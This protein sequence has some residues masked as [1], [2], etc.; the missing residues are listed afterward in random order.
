MKVVLFCGGY[1]TRLREYSETIPKPLVE[2]GYRPIIWHLMKYYAHFGHKDFILAL[3]YRGDLIKDYFLQY[4]ECM[5]NDFVLT[6]G[7]RN[8]ELLSS[9]IDDW[10]ITFCDTGPN[11]NIGQRL[12]RVRHLLDGDDMFLAN[13]SDGL[14]DLPLDKQL[15]EMNKNGSVVSF[16]CVRPSY[17]LSTVETNAKGQVTAIRYM[18]E[19]DTR[20]NGG[21][22]ILRSEIFNFIKEGEELVEEPFGR[23]I[24]Q[25]KLSAYEYDGFWAAM[26]TFK[27]KVQ[28]DRMVS[29]GEVPWQVWDAEAK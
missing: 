7:G 14:S 16:A 5:S 22:M 3:G 20:I 12:L 28:F 29:R 26:D 10:R 17:S 9:D 23:L 25:R 19:S 8:V 6:E 27:D 2:I 1:G 15:A 4:N 24:E 13:Y 21:F 18:S 11:S